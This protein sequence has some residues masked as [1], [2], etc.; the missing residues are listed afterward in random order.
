MPDPELNEAQELTIGALEGQV[1]GWEQDQF[2]VIVQKPDG[3]T[4]SVD[5]EGEVIELPEVLSPDDVDVDADDF[6]PTEVDLAVDALDPRDVFRAMDR[7]DE[8]EILDELAGRAIASMVYSF[9]QGKGKFVTDLSYNG[10]NETIRL[11]NERGGTRIGIHDVP[12]IVEPLEV[13]GK[14][15]VRVMAYAKDERTNAGRWGMDLEPEM[16]KAGQGEKWDKFAGT[17]ALSKAQRNALRAFI[18]EEFRQQVIGLAVADGNVTKLKPLGAG[19][20]PGG[21]PL[22]QMVEPVSGPDA[23]RLRGEIKEAYE[24]LKAGFGLRP[25]PGQRYGLLFEAAQRQEPREQAIEAM[26]RFL[27]YIEGIAEAEIEKATEEGGA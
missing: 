16:M 5:L 25:L 4:V 14:R 21:T 7:N 27:A 20:L 15:Y 24:E 18:P 12:P 13:E 10:V 17:K 11:M 3:E 2:T 23:D 9:E 26:E 6:K 19:T 8:V 1:I 22:E